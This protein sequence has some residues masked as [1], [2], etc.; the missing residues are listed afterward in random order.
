MTEL[1]VE[2]DPSS[3]P[4]P[5]PVLAGPRSSYR[6]LVFEAKG[7]RI[8]RGKPG[9]QVQIYCQVC[10]LVCS[11]EFPDNYDNKGFVQGDFPYLMLCNRHY[12]LMKRL[13][14]STVPLDRWPT[15]LLRGLMYHYY[16]LEMDVKNRANNARQGIFMSQQDIANTPTTERRMV[17]VPMMGLGWSPLGGPESM[18]NYGFFTP[19]IREVP[20]QGAA[21]RIAANQQRIRNLSDWAA[22]C[23]SEASRLDGEVQKYLHLIQ[24]SVSR[25]GAK[26][27]SCLWCHQS[28]IPLKAKHCPFCGKSEAVMNNQTADPVLV[29]EA[30]PIDAVQD[31]M[32]KDLF[33]AGPTEFMSRDATP[34]EIKT[35]ADTAVDLRK[36]RDEANAEPEPSVEEVLANAKPYMDE[37]RT[38]YLKCDECGNTDPDKSDGLNCKVCVV[39]SMGGFMRQYASKERLRQQIVMENQLGPEVVAALTPALRGKVEER[40]ESGFLSRLEYKNAAGPEMREWATRINLPGGFLYYLIPIESDDFHRYDAGRDILEAA[41]ADPSFPKK[42]LRMAIAQYV[43]RRINYGLEADGLR[44]SAQGEFVLASPNSVAMA[45]DAMEKAKTELPYQIHFTIFLD[46]LLKHYGVAPKARMLEAVKKKF[47]ALTEF[48]K[49]EWIPVYERFRTA[50]PELPGQDI[51]DEVS[52]L[53]HYRSNVNYLIPDPDDFSN[54][55]KV[56]QVNKK[57]K[58]EEDAIKARLNELAPSGSKASKVASARDRVINVWGL[59][60]QEQE[61]KE[62]RIYTVEEWKQVWGGLMTAPKWKEYELPGGPNPYE[63]VLAKELGTVPAKVASKQN[64]PSHAQTTAAVKGGR[65]KRSVATQKTKNAA[66]QAQP[67]GA[68]DGAATSGS[69]PKVRFC[70][71]CGAEQKLQEAK[72]CYGCGAKLEGLL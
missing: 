43:N 58:V 70:P 27:K 24:G 23:D 25:N 22:E 39:E 11:E 42:A 53:S 56:A 62:K 19:G 57:R 41:F 67:S 20:V 65:K 37:N 14:D 34:E 49:G 5:A 32:F 8:Q 68:K 31:Y 46:D 44:R 59:L 3:Y 36:I 4:G 61:E 30:D 38:V 12:R 69:V 1:W 71:M 6:W 51:I 45:R 7:P 35:M 60:V 10:S 52:R 16:E 55:A 63:A 26:F 29:E 40:I 50:D 64:T 54:K 48:E 2:V 72:F 9:R 66:P 13:V 15:Q 18:T 21:E 33:S 47:E 17:P 28:E